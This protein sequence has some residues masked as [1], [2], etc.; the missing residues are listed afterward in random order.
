MNLLD[1]LSFVDYFMIN[2]FCPVVI[3]LLQDRN[4]FIQC[5]ML[6]VRLTECIFEEKFFHNDLELSLAY[7]HIMD[8]LHQVDHIHVSS[9]G[10][11]P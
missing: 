11:L 7:D 8:H 1:L 10:V 3:S 9:E 2:N 6:F 4:I 5:C